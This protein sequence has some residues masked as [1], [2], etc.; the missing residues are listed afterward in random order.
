MSYYGT[1]YDDNHLA[2]HGIKGMK[3]GIRKSKDSYRTLGVGKRLRSTASNLKS[4]AKSKRGK[5]IIAAG[6]GTAA[7]IGAAAG[8]TG[9][10]IAKRKLK[11]Y[12]NAGSGNG[13]LGINNQYLIGT[14]KG[15]AAAP[16]RDPISNNRRN[17]GPVA[18]QDR[19]DAVM[20][21][22]RA[23]DINNRIKAGKYKF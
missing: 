23:K 19:M 2:H 4:F 20:Q 6:V 21:Y 16:G 7:G 12:N 3:W 13:G 1:I 5:R 22:R 10:I 14:N 11:G 9:G 18:S 8:I 15:R 17:M